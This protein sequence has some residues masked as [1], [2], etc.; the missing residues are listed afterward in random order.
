LECNRECS[1]ESVFS[2]LPKLIFFQRT[3][4]KPE[5]H[6]YIKQPVLLIHVGSPLNQYCGI[7]N[8]C[9][10]GERNEGC[11]KK[12]AE[13]LASQLLNAEGGAVIYTVKG[14]NCIRHEVTLRQFSAQVEPELSASFQDM[15]Q[16][17]TRFSQ[18]L[19]P[20]FR[21]VGQTSHP[22]KLQDESE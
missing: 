18:N 15:P 14:L 3:P 16:S 22:L 5:V 9:C 1:R 11:P 19:F 21:A 4:L 7:A 12:Y 8:I 17:R 10:K 20:D 2:C 13:K 6:A